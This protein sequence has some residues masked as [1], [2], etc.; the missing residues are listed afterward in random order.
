MLIPDLSP[1]M[2]T[3]TFTHI[4]AP[5][6]HEISKVESFTPPV[7]YNRYIQV[8]GCRFIRLGAGFNVQGIL[9]STTWRLLEQK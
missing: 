5:L 9:R 6:P 7:R 3:S 8:E 2:G 4:E 1:H